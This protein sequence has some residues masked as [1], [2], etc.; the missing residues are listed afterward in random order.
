MIIHPQLGELWKSWLSGHYDVISLSSIDQLIP[1]LEAMPGYAP[2]L[3]LV[4]ADV[5]PGTHDGLTLAIELAA[6]R[7]P[8]CVVSD[9]PKRFARRG[10]TSYLTPVS[11]AQL[12]AIVRQMLAG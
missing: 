9:E 8:V 6:L 4:T 5:T 10:V 2:D 1:A 3:Y 11:A 7:Q 12:L